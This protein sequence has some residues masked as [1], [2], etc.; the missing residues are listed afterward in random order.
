DAEE[1]VESIDAWI[2]LVGRLAFVAAALTVLLRIS[3]PLTLAVLLPLAGVVALVNLVGERTR[4]YRAGARE[5]TGDVTGFLGELFGGVQA[6]AVAGAAPHAVARL[7]RLGDTRRRAALTDRVFGDLIGAFYVNAAPVAPGL[8]LLLAAGAMRAG[9]FSVGD[10]ALFVALL[11][12]VATFGDE[13]AR[14]ITGYRRAG[15]AV[16]RL[17]ALVP[18][19]RIAPLVATG[20]PFLRRPPRPPDLTPRLGRRAADRLDVLEVRG[21]SAHHPGGR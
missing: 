19:A 16:G 11:P 2:D 9:D 20:A 1:L 7:R 18:G 21:L 10:L 4:R 13:V 14:W 5:A 8:L 15:V 3:V 17:A 12:E 6:I